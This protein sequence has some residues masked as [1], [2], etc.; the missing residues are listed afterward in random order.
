MS[1]TSQ[2][3]RAT[4]LLLEEMTFEQVEQYLAA[5]DRVI[6][7]FGSV[8]QNGRHLPLG[9][10][11]MI[12]RAIAALV[13]RQT[14]VIVA[15]AIP[16]GNASA[17]MAFAGSFSL[18]PNVLN[19][20]IEGLALNL[21][22]HGLRRVMFLSGHL[23]NVWSLALI[24]GELRDRG[25]LVMQAD[26]W[27]LM[28]KLCSDLVSGSGKKRSNG[29]AG[30]LAT[31]VMMAINADLVVNDRLAVNDPREGW[32]WD[33]YASYP[34]VMGFAR[35]EDVSESGAVGDSRRASKEAGLEALDRIAAHVVSLLE[36]VIGVELPTP[37]DRMRRD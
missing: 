5:D 24:A 13:S 27:R 2:S 35:W 8:E 28:Q 33:T 37:I 29:H 1:R 22:R 30:E 4:P 26:T 14:G 15:P 19:D 36:Q 6:V 10:D 21:S 9:T 12:V 17:D 16:W 20:L 23:S 18:H 25:L 32:A 31:S 3:S 34:T 7:P 11:L